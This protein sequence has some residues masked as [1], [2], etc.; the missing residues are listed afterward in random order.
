MNPLGQLSISYYFLRG[1]EWQ[2]GTQDIGNEWKVSGK[3]LRGGRTSRSVMIFF[4]DVQLGRTGR[5]DLL[6]DHGRKNAAPVAGRGVGDVALT[7][8]QTATGTLA[9]LKL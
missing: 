7:I 8:D 6:C 5:S 3:L 9:G 1:P 4:E 2:T